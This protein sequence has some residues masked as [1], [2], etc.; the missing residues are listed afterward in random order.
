M[1]A[2]NKDEAR[3]AKNWTSANYGNLEYVSPQDAS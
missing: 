3:C 1:L 2:V